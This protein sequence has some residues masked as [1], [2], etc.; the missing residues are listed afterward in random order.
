MYV[1]PAVAAVLTH[2]HAIKRPRN[3]RANHQAKASREGKPKSEYKGVSAN[4]NV[5]F[6]WRAYIY[7]RGGRYKHLGIFPTE[8]K[9]ARCYDREARAK[10]EL[11]APPLTESRLHLSF[12]KNLPRRQI[13]LEHEVLHVL[14]TRD[15]NIADTRSGRNGASHADA[16]AT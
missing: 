14:H 9:A 12:L 1:Q 7:D 13:F 6:P 11:H 4:S 5:D 8:D 16:Y 3:A 15:C 2:L 10:A